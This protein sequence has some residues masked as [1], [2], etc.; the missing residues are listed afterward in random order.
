MAL[1][2]RPLKVTD[3]SAI[4]D[5]IRADSSL[6]YQRRIPSAT[7]AG[8]ETVLNDLTKYNV[9][10]NEFVSA[11]INQIGLVLARNTSWTNPLATFKRGLLSFGDTIE[12]IQTG[13]LEAH[14]YDPDREYMERD[15]FGTEVPEVQVNFHKLNRQNFYRLTVNDNLLKR[16]FFSSEGLSKFAGQLMQSPS[17]SDQWDEFLLMCQLFAKYENNGGFN[18]VHVPRV[19]KEGS[20]GTDARTAL[21]KIRAMSNTLGFLSTK[22]NAARMPVAAR[23][24][25]LVLFV[26]PDFQ[27]AIDVEALAGAFNVDKLDVQNRIFPIPTEQFGIDGVQAILTVKDFF[28]VGDT[29]FD[30]TSQFNPIHRQTNYFLHRQQIISASRFVPAVMFWDGPDDEVIVVQTPTTS[31]DAITIEAIDGTVPTDATRGTMLQLVSKANTTPAGGSSS[32]MW[33]V[34]GNQSTRTYITASGVLH[35]GEDENAS[36]VTVTVSSTYVDPINTRK[37]FATA[38]KVLNVVGSKL[39]TWPRNGAIVGINVKGTDVP[40]FSAGTLTY[41][42]TMTGATITPADVLV[43]SDGPVDAVV[44]VSK[45][46]NIYTVTIA[47]DPGV[48]AGS[49]YTLTITT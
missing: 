14:V 19:S 24:D 43:Y 46:T 9:H 21:R 13:L 48:G 34:S 33:S 37:D 15:I 27:A 32:V 18:H 25:E 23:P 17:T 22:Y 29:V 6:E 20:S 11:L 41:S 3:N 42:M 36:S 7:D 1:D 4:L 45:S 39:G 31:V 40:A 8:I 28:V 5:A 10:Y 30:T 47:L 44:T 16:A 35:V 2:V 12:E 38:T 26:T 49:T